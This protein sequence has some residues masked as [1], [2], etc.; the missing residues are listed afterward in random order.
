MALPWG[1]KGAWNDSTEKNLH[2]GLDMLPLGNRKIMSY[3]LTPDGAK[4][5]TLKQGNVRNV[6]PL[7]LGALAK[8]VKSFETKE[9]AKDIDRE[10]RL[11]SLS[12]V[13]SVPYGTVIGRH[14]T[15]MKLPLT[16]TA[17][18]GLLSFT[19]GLNYRDMDAHWATNELGEK[20]TSALFSHCALSQ[21]RDI[22]IRTADRADVGTVIRSVHGSGS[23]ASYSPYSNSRMLDG[24]LNNASEF[25]EAPVLSME[26]Y[27]DYMRLRLA[28]PTKTNNGYQQ[29]KPNDMELRKPIGT[30]NLKNSSTGKSAV[31]AEGGIWTLI[32]TNG[33]VRYTVEARK[34]RKHVGDM[35]RLDEWYHGAIESILTSQ[36]GILDQYE[37][38]LSVH[39]DNIS[40][41][42]KQALEA[43]RSAGRYN[44][45]SDGLIDKVVKQGLHDD[46]TPQNNSVA[47]AA[48]AISLVA[49]SNSSFENEMLMEELADWTLR[50]GLKEA[51]GT[52]GTIRVAL[53]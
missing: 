5:H 10:L 44:F 1:I 2:K 37:A 17:L 4:L 6:Q 39:V 53:A 45:L 12:F 20:I 14:G 26:L 34:T 25:A 11:V 8:G 32:C 16:K 29:M 21:N 35:R 48:Q 49:Q 33:I 43:A 24:I 42:T 9:N 27:D 18:Q 13:D 28:T 22:M 15:D 38:A 3:K 30:V 36:Y 50:R 52:D 47:Q 40:E 19:P 31:V 23:G 51:N 7:D 46:T 41:W